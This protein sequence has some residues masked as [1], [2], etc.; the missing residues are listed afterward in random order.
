MKR[1]EEIRQEFTSTLQSVLPLLNI[2]RFSLHAELEHNKNPKF[3]ILLL[4]KVPITAVKDHS[5]TGLLKKATLFT[6]L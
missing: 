2:Y 4:R 6:L 3:L 5:I 1:L